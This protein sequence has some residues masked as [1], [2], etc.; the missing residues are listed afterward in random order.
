MRAGEIVFTGME[1][2]V[3][4]HPAAKAVAEAADRLGARRV[5]ILA[6]RTLNRDTD[7]VRQIAEALGPR[8]AGV[9]DEMPAHSPRD[10]VIACA[11]KARD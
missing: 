1:R 8:Y 2:V 9:H 10:A 6:G 5:F 3:F 7:A 4:G 11:N